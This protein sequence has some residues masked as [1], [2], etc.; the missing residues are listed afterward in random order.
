MYAQEAIR[1]YTESLQSVGLDLTTAGELVGV[2]SDKELEIIADVEKMVRAK[3]EYEG[4][5]LSQESM[6]QLK[7]ECG[8]LCTNT[9]LDPK[10]VLRDAIMKVKNAL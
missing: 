6:F 10:H 8:V 7:N 1:I 9:S 5:P 2:T 3:A 4:M